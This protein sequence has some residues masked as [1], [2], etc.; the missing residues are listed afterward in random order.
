MR[1]AAVGSCCAADVLQSGRW[2]LMLHPA[3][4]MQAH[5]AG[6]HRP[7]TYEQQQRR[8]VQYHGAAAD[9]KHKH[10]NNMAQQRQATTL[11]C[12]SVGK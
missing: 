12:Q 6:K 5:S 1:G 4:Q 3:S 7:R 11:T 8:A 9:C 10:N 2:D